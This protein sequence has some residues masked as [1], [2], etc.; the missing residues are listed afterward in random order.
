MHVQ[1]LSLKHF[2]EI[3][4]FQSDVEISS[5]VFSGQLEMIVMPGDSGPIQRK[6]SPSWGA[7]PT[8]IS[9]VVISLDFSKLTTLPPPA[10][11]TL[12]PLCKE[13]GNLVA[14]D[15]EWLSSY[16]RNKRRWSIQRFM[17]ESLQLWPGADS[18]ICLLGTS[19]GS[20]WPCSTPWMSGTTPLPGLSLPMQWPAASTH[21]LPVLLTPSAPCPPAPGTSATSLIMEPLPYTASV[22][23]QECALVST[24]RCRLYGRNVVFS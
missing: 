17:I 7:L 23:P 5:T 11:L 24:H 19:C 1:L 14:G 10:R 6:G 9:W 15:G 8:C 3:N 12:P 2:S 13:E 4:L 21:W 18:M 16:F 20:C 22:R